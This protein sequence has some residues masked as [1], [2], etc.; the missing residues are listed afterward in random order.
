MS[1]RWCGPWAPEVG[2]L[3]WVRPGDLYTS[4]DINDRQRQPVIGWRTTYTPEPPVTLGMVV[5]RLDGSR[6]WTHLC[7]LIP[8]HGP[9]WLSLTESTSVKIKKLR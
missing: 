3:V 8:M 2:E 9:G 5:C 4:R 7:V 1:R 6:D